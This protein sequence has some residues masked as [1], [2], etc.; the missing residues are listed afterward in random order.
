MHIA[1]MFIKTEGVVL[2]YIKKV[3]SIHV[4]GL[5]TTC[6]YQNCGEKTGF[7]VPDIF[8]SILLCIY[9]ITQHITKK[10]SC[11]FYHFTCFSIKERDIVWITNYD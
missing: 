2:R 7:N 6:I 10:S 11:V 8:F 4:I 1:S 3:K 9:S 5:P